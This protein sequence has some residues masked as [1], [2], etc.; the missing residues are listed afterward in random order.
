MAVKHSRTEFV[1]FL[2]DS[3]A[4]PDTKC[5]LGNTSMHEAFKKDCLIVSPFW[6]D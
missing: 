3:G 6:Y 4:D 5:E 2:L 1:K